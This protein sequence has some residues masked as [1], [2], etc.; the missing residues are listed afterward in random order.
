MNLIKRIVDMAGE[1]FYN[2]ME[3]AAL[4]CFIA[5]VIVWADIIRSIQ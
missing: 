1:A 3:L 4:G 5:A 2:V